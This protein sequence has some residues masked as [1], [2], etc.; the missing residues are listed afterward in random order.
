MAYR[1][2]LFIRL[3]R[4]LRL[5][6]PLPAEVIQ[7]MQLIRAIDAGGLPLNPARVNQIARN[8]GLEVSIHASTDTTLERIRAALTR[9]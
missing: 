3:R 1:S 9:I 4:W 5:A 8:L 2:M 6:P 7:A